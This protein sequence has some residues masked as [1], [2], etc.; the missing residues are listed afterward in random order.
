MFSIDVWLVV[1]VI[2]GLAGFI[3]LATVFSIRA[4]RKAVSAGREDL[5]GRMA[6]VVT[7]LDPRGT[8]LVEGER[9]AAVLDNGKAK[10]GEEVVITKVEG[11]RLVVTKEGQRR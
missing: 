2:I 7:P 3:A 8:V 9:W 1:L 10:I 4:H 6:Q 11:L 5:I